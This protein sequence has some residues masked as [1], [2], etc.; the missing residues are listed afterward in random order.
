MISWGGKRC[1]IKADGNELL[2]IVEVLKSKEGPMSTSACSR[3]R[4][5]EVGISPDILR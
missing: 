3:L 2:G 4:M 1:E 5:D